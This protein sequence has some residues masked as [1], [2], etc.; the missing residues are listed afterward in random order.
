MHDRKQRGAGKPVQ[1]GPDSSGP[2]SKPSRPSVGGEPSHATGLGAGEENARDAHANTPL[3]HPIS[4]R[5][6]LFNFD[7]Q[8]VRVVGSWESPRFIAK[9]VCAA[10]E[11]SNHNDA[12]SSLDDDEKG[13]AT[14]D[15]LG[16]PQ[17][18]SVISESGLYALIFRSRK[19]SA[20]LFRRWV[21]GEVLPAI[22]RSGGYGAPA[23]MPRPALAVAQPVGMLM[24][25]DPWAEHLGRLL[26]AAL[27]ETS[28]QALTVSALAGHAVR[29]G[30]LFW[31]ITDAADW[32][33]RVSLGCSL[34]K[35]AGVVY[36]LPGGGHAMFRTVGKCGRDRR[37]LIERIPPP[38]APPD[39]SSLGEGGAS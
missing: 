14:T 18:M 4:Q 22:R 35:R 3:A 11:I 33:G 20:R 1:S 26:E 37:Y 38:I 21:T 9:D 16:G 7:A 39:L 25:A 8:G 19:P 12:I 6:R 2:Q 27:G 15:T 30:A 13:V 17:E 23:A 29:V 24:K 28:A 10:L 31:L 36:A 34:R 5:P 32:H